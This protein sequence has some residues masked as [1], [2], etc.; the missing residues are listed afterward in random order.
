M[1]K[2]LPL[3]LCIVI[4]ISISPIDAL[5]SGRN[6]SFEES[7]A[8]DLRTLG[9]FRGVSDTNFDLNRAPTRTEALVM[10]IRVLG[11]EDAA[12][13]GN[14][15]HPFTDVASWAD[16]YVGYA[17]A[18]NLTNGVS[19]TEFGTGNANAAMYVTFVLR[20]LEYDD[21]NGAD[22]TWNNPFTL[23]KTVGILP[24]IVNTSVFWRSDVVVVSYSALSVYLKNS[25][26]TLAAKLI[27]AGV[28][29][30]ALFNT[31]YDA[32]AIRDYIPPVTTELEP[33]AIYS[34]CSP[35]VFYIELYNSNEIVIGSGS[36]FFI[37]SSGIA[38]TNYHVIEGASSAKITLS[39]NNAVYDVVGVYD[40]SEQEDWAII[41]INGSGFNTLQIGDMSTVVGAATIYA[42]GSPLG[43]QST[44]SQGIISNP[45]RIDGGV[46]HIQI[47]AA[48]SPGSSGG[49]LINKYGD[50][51]GITTSQYIQGQNL[52]LALPISYIEGH[53]RNDIVALSALFP[54]GTGG[55]ITDLSTSVE[56]QSTGGEVYVNG[57]TLYA[58]TPNQSDIWVISTLDEGN[59]DPVLSLYDSSGTQLA[60]NDDYFSDYNAKII[61]YFE[62]GQTY[63][64]EVSFYD[65]DYGNCTLSVSQSLQLSG[66]GGT[67]RV[68]G[69]SIYTFIPSQSGTWTFRTSNS[70]NFDPLIRVFNDTIATIGIGDDNAGDLDAMVAMHLEAG[71]TYIIEVW[72]YHWDASTTLT[73]TS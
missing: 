64:I 8:S 21:T 72:F 53:S 33:E 1:K 66:S 22:F 57:R 48:I 13:N 15:R 69:D 37:D 47:T 52:N 38:V 11:K 40:Y 10:L 2:T 29:T 3:I 41:K 28:F 27:E 24:D 30:Q 73:W 54:G 26:Q 45:N 31:T 35:A 12:L 44:I 51:I 50:V 32:D 56:L 16:N 18:N 4:C 49:A 43:L 67:V 71:K 7:L 58:I 63:Y 19:A 46:N 5:A 6:T 36:G 68:N 17:Y 20:A 59:N 25:T 39:D 34:M 61:T 65:S 9:L 55:T 42:I 60:Y 70:G 62:T 14:Y 23:A